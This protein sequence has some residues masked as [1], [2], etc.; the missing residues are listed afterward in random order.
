MSLS[1]KDIKILIVDDDKV[2][3]DILS[4]M[5][6]MSDFVVEQA[7]NGKEALEKIKIN[8]PDI[9]ILDCIMP[10]MDGFETFVNL[11]RNPDTQD[12]S[13]MFCSAT[14]IEEAKNRGLKADGYIEK[15]FIIEDLLKKINEIIKAKQ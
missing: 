3:R 6:S 10:V 5:L 15:P 2:L 9:I 12:I 11:K 7:G 14:H 13:I 8:K 1:K 4:H